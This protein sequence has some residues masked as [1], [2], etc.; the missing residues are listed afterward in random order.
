[1]LRCDSTSSR[2]H[3]QLVLVV[4]GGSTTKKIPTSDKVKS[5]CVHLNLVAQMKTVKSAA[6]GRAFGFR[7]TFDDGVG[8]NIELLVCFSDDVK[9]SL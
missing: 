6:S 4:T 1:M 2:S 9:K 3:C 8:S 7:L 5:F